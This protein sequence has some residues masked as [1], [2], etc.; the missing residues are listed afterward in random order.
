MPPERL[1]EMSGPTAIEKPVR[2]VFVEPSWKMR[3]EFADLIRHPPDGYRFIQTP[4]ISEGLAQRLARYS[5]FYK[6]H[7][8]LLKFLPIQLAKPYWERFKRLPPNVDL[9]YAVLHPVFRREPWVLDMRLEQPHLLVGSEAVFRRWRGLLK[10]AFTSRFCRRII[11]ELEAGKQAFLQL[12]GWHEL[13]PKMTVVNSAVPRRRFAKTRR[14][15]G[16]PRFK[17]LFVNSANINADKHFYAHG[18]SVL[19]A[20]FLRV[21]QRYDNVELVIRSDIPPNIKRHLRGIPNLRVIDTIIPWEELEKEFMTAD[22]F[23]YPTHVTPSIVLLDAMSYEL[24]IVTTDVWGN[25]ELVQNG[26]AGLLVHH[27]GAKDYTDGFIVHFDSR[28]WQRA[29]VSVDEKLVQGVVEKV[30][31]LIEDPELRRRLGREGRQEVEE[32]KFSTK[33][34]NEALKQVLDEAI[35]GPLE[36]QRHDER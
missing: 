6:V 35:A 16:N 27:L 28:A 7:W 23:V 13:E 15:Q 33:R 32:G 8:Q 4:T 18:G 22:I 21:Q 19:L 2:T 30:S 9:T 34:R 3:Q 25:P 31:L 24:P 26:G 12:T 10:P 1:H 14:D 17:L 29:I 11:F 36:G 20:A 5:L